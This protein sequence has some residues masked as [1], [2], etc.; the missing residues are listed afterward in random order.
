V[1]ESWRLYHCTWCTENALAKTLL[2]KTPVVFRLQN[3]LSGM[4]D[5]ALSSLVQ[6]YLFSEER[7]A[8]TCKVNQYSLCSL[9]SGCLLSLRVAHKFLQN[10]DK[11]LPGYTASHS[12]FPTRYRAKPGIH[13]CWPFGQGCPL[14]SE[15]VDQTLKADRRF[16]FDFGFPDSNPFSR[17]AVLRVT[18]FSC[19][20]SETSKKDFKY[21]PSYCF[22]PQSLY[23]IPGFVLY[24]YLLCVPKMPPFPHMS[25]WRGA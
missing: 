17:D 19:Y 21:T 6:P 2:N 16:G 10:C 9:L 5:V 13:I 20:I 4:R 22:V 25:P 14:R 7:A 8:T 3:T 24:I 15:L 1:T 12:S 11:L 23:N 18:V